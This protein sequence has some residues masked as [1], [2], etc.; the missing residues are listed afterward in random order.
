MRETRACPPKSMELKQHFQNYFELLLSTERAKLQRVLATEAEATDEQ[1]SN[2]IEQRIAYLK[3]AVRM[4]KLLCLINAEEAK[5]KH[6][7]LMTERDSL[8]ANC[9]SRAKL[10]K[11]A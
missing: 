5:I 10:A 8:L 4:G 7:I 3:G 11:H 6:D 1:L 2:E 9:N